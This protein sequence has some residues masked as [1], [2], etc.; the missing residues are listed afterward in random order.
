MQGS[1]SMGGMGI[2]GAHVSAA[3]PHGAVEHFLT[4]AA[5]GPAST[6]TTVPMTVTPSRRRAISGDGTT[7]KVS[8]TTGQRPSCLVNA[9][10]TYCGDNQIYAFGGFDSYTDEVYNHVLKLDLTTLRWTLVDNYGDIPGVRMG[11]T[12]TLY[13][14]D[15]LIIFGGENEHR[16]YLSDIVIFDLKTAYWTQPAVS[17]PIPR[18]RARH[19]AALY[20]D[21]LFIV[22]GMTGADSVADDICYLDLTTLTWSRAW[23]F[24]RRFDQA[25]WVWGD[26]LWVFGGLGQ[27][28]SRDGE[29]WWLDLKA[30][31]AFGVDTAPA[32]SAARA[33]AGRIFSPRSAAPIH[34]TYGAGGGLGM[35]G[36]GYGV[37]QGAGVHANASL[38]MRPSQTP[39]APGIS[40]LN[41][42]SSPEYPPQ[43]SGTHFYVYSSNA[44]LDFVTP[45]NTIRPTDC[46]LAA[47]DLPSLRWQ[48]LAEG[49][50]VF[51]PGYRWHYCASDAEGTKAWL[52]G[53]ATDRQ[54]GH[55][56]GF[57]EYLCDVLAID[58]RRFGL[59]GNSTVSELG[60]RSSGSTTMRSHVDSSL[61]G[62]GMDMARMFDRSP[63]LGS[64]AD[65]VVTADPDEDRHSSD[66]VDTPSSP[67]PVPGASVPAAQPPPPAS[68]PIHVHLLI[69]KARWEH[70]RRLYSS[71]MIESRTNIMHI[72]EPYSVVRAFLFYL[73]TDS[74]ARHPGYGNEL[75]SSEVAGLLVMANMYDLPGLRLLC[76]HRLG[77]ELEV[78][79]AAVV[80]ERAG[81]ANEEWL[82]RRAASFCLK[83]WGRV[84]RTDAFRKLSRESLGELCEEVDTEGRVIN[85]GELEAV[86]GL[87][88]G[89]LGLGAWG[90]A[91]PSI[92]ASSSGAGR[93]GDSL[94]EV[95]GDDD[96]EMEMN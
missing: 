2:V 48:R 86:G 92:R 3:N 31:P 43:A 93:T 94:D 20:K 75:D 79:H 56:G 29:V 19:A 10:V 37:S 5:L 26:K 12:A 80:W 69:L 91:S 83:H 44:L 11:H 66:D 32:R 55:D 14:G 89:R 77:R 53:C 6:T 62:L 74:I 28:M 7:P 85:G 82:R 13:Q 60:V 64:G 71:G 46:G 90:R 35:A 63:D 67:S 17:G 4:A 84:V 81:M 88:G 76:V 87:G 1:V 34:P 49:A 27:D 38:A 18:G 41:F 45:A 70:F 51:H 8:R 47:L 16:T 36:L 25:A 72:P 58:L 21:K 24:V 65:F 61:C 40:S 96:G 73:Y 39:I 30:D 50:E 68:P 33:D 9:S 42:L 57:E 95:D 78:E 59:L 22:G 52:L 54:S 15:K 23:T